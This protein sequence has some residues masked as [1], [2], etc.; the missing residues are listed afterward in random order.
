MQI[1]NMHDV[2]TNLSRLVEETVNSGAVWDGGSRMRRRT[3]R[4][5]SSH[6]LSARRDR[7]ELPLRSNLTGRAARLPC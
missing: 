6:S 5:V 1:Y 4:I 2:R 7:R 3:R